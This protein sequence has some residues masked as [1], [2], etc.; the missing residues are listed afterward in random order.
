MMGVENGF[1]ERL[2]E[3]SRT[4]RRKSPST[5]GEKMCSY[6]K[7]P[8]VSRLARS[9][10]WLAACCSCSL[11]TSNR[12]RPCRTTSPKRWRDLYN[13]GPLADSRI[14]RSLHRPQRSSTRPCASHI[15]RGDTRCR[16]QSFRPQAS[17]SRENPGAGLSR[18]PVQS[19]RPAFFHT[20]PEYSRC[21]CSTTAHRR[22]RF[23]CRSLANDCRST[24][25]RRSRIACGIQS[26]VDAA[27][28]FLH[29]A[30]P[31]AHSPG[32][33]RTVRATRLAGFVVFRRR[34]DRR[35][36]FG[37]DLLACRYLSQSPRYSQRPGSVRF[38]IP[39]GS[40]SALPPHHEMSQSPAAARRSHKARTRVASRLHCLNYPCCT[41]GGTGSHRRLI[42]WN[43]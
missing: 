15:V 24:E 28:H 11:G 38:E 19:L 26:R 23:P 37:A 29:K 31:V 27:R 18:S 22:P 30:S 9:W 1:D 14:D 6:D 3:S 8:M 4:I 32:R 16:Y 34:F 12:E 41:F 2:S 42:Q 25:R 36:R 21:R 13:F 35:F 39:Q 20:R 5:L 40:P 10:R 33:L 17:P 7:I 43:S